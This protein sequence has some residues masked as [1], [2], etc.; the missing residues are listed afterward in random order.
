MAATTPNVTPLKSNR[1]TG[2]SDITNYEVICNVGLGTFGSVDKAKCRATGKVVALKRIFMHNEKDG[3]PITSLREIKLL[4]TLSHVNVLHLDEMAIERVKAKERKKATLYMVTPYMD[5]DLSGL[6]KNTDVKITV[7]Q[8]KCYMLQLLEGLRYLHS[9]HIIHRDMKA[10]NLLINN[11]GILQIADFG[12]ARY[13]D[14]PSPKPG[15]GGGEAKREYTGLVVTR[16]YRPPEL[17]LNLKKY[18]SAI[19]LWGVGCVFGEM[20][21]KRPILMG[22][23]DL[24]QIHMIFDLVGSPNDEN[25]PGWSELPGCEGT[26]SFDHK[27]G[28]IKEQFKELSPSGV[29]LLSDLMTLD[30]RTRINAHDALRHPYFSTEPL[31]ARPSDIPRYNDSHELDQRRVGDKKAEPPPAPKGG[32]VG[33]G[34]EGEWAPHANGGPSR[35]YRRDGPGW[36]PDRRDRGPPPRDE[37]RVPPQERAPPAYDSRRPAHA[38]GP[39]PPMRQPGWVRPPPDNPPPHPAHDSL[40]PRPANDN[41][42][43][44]PPPTAH[45]HPNNRPD[46]VRPSNGPPGPPRQRNNAPSKDTYIPTYSSAHP[47]DREMPDRQDILDRRD[48]HDRRDL[49]DRREY[50]RRDYRDRDCASRGNSR[51]R[52]PYRDPDRT[53]RPPPPRRDNHN[54]D[55]HERDRR[56]F[57]RGRDRDRDRERDR[58]YNGRPQPYDERDRDR[59]RRSDSY[60]GGLPVGPPGGAAN[61]SGL[62]Y[63][64]SA[65][66]S[67]T[68]RMG[69]NRRRTRSRS[70][71]AERRERDKQREERDRNPYGRR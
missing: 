4:K 7:P 31:P 30:W 2:C 62:P 22:G 25:M 66:G 12:L 23:T 35:D 6:L 50:D 47:H 58:A 15:K 18:T 71:G 44:R 1:F 39:P 38:G 52:H 3:F 37:R 57:D 11:A 5:H 42:P 49:P 60:G 65:S 40:P 54:R 68:S 32:A 56:D 48:Q 55:Y 13:Y 24:G 29:S 64:G 59:G 16:W 53:D 41:L 27:A 34:P 21:K 61:G 26:K 9:A 69:G 45:P 14:E 33:M 70:P 36:A 43:P 17:L 8:I 51:E 46:D 28:N 10:A 63:G 19:D 67:D 20:F